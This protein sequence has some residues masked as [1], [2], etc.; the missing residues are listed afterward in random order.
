MADQFLSNCMSYMSVKSWKSKG[1]GRD[2]VITFELGFKKI[3]KSPSKIR[4]DAERKRQ[5]LLRKFQKGKEHSTDNSTEFYSK[6]NSDSESNFDLESCRSELSAE[7]EKELCPDTEKPDCNGNSTTE[8]YVF[9]FSSV[10]SSEYTHD[11]DTCSG[12]PE[13]TPLESLS[14]VCSAYGKDLM[15]PSSSRNDFEHRNQGS[16]TYNAP[17]DSKPTGNRDLVSI[18]V[19]LI[20]IGIF[21]LIYIPV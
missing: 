10:L 17:K 2:R 21:L 12:S 18:V 3:H 9:Q 15:S 6:E 14:P 7:I 5:Y 20:F 16:S 4:R 8:P 13:L 19:T 11:I 1:S